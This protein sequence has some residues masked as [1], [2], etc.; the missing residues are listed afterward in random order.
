VSV[1]LVAPEASARVGRSFPP[2]IIS[3]PLSRTDRLTL[4]FSIV[5]H[6]LFLL[7]LTIVSLHTSITLP[8]QSHCPNLG[9]FYFTLATATVATG[10]LSA[11]FPSAIAPPF[12]SFLLPIL[13]LRLTAPPTAHQNLN[14]SFLLPS[15]IRISPPLKAP[16][17]HPEAPSFLAQYSGFKS[18]WLFKTFS[19][20]P[21]LGHRLS[22]NL[23]SSPSIPQSRSVNPSHNHIVVQ[24]T[25]IDPKSSS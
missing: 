18:N 9:K 19:Y 20:K 6:T 16:S 4:S 5:D 17:R 22:S 1:T 8:A 14:L 24:G 11:S 7:Y 21:I 12:H 10:F 2:S 25:N 13:P 15:S 23:P 3:P